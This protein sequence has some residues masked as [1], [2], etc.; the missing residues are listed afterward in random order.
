M[1]S[2]I[3]VPLDG[4]PLAEAVLS[5]VIEIAALKKSEIV[6][7]RVALAHGIFGAEQVEAQVRVV[8][9]AQAYLAKIE[10][11]LAAQGFAVRSVVRYG[12]A[13]DEILDH[14]RMG[15]VGMIAMSTHGRGGVRRWVLGS[16]AETVVRHSPVPV[17]LVRAAEPVIA[18]REA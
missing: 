9:E 18:S 12:H 7:L 5:Q 6:L 2:R 8:E 3:L 16:V 13:A 15:G 11:S 10:A 4:S 14:A 17:L 1:L